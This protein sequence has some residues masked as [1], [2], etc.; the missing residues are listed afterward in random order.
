[1]TKPDNPDDTGFSHCGA[2]RQSAQSIVICRRRW[3]IRCVVASFVVV[4][5]TLKEILVSK[6]RKYCNDKNVPNLHRH[7]MIIVICCRC[8]DIRCVATSSVDLE[9][10][11]VSKNKS[12]VI[13]QNVPNSY[14]RPSAA[15][16]TVEA[17]FDGSKYLKLKRSCLLSKTM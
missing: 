12:T 17:I 10:I 11:L 1:L 6:K 15:L 7:R 2:T 14:T 5:K 8:W 9:E 16:P 3:V 4:E 13:I